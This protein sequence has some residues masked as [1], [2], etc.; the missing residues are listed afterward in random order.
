MTRELDTLYKLRELFS[1]SNRWCRKKYAINVEGEEVHPISSKAVSWCTI[2]AVEKCA[3]NKS[4]TI[5]EVT[6][7]LKR[8]CYRI[9]ENKD[10]SYVNDN[11]GLDAVKRVIEETITERE[12]HE[13]IELG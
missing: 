12:K 1:D 3:F 13:S 10:L 6:Y 4:T 7:L 5:D 9:Y 8:T 2:G 11:L